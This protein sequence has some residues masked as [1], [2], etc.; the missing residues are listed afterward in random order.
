MN[1]VTLTW[2][3]KNNDLDA[4]QR[5]KSFF[6]DNHLICE[7]TKEGLYITCNDKKNAFSY[8]WWCMMELA[9]HVW[10]RNVVQSCVW[11]DGYEAEDV[12]LSTEELIAE[13]KMDLYE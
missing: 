4:H 1:E 7:E 2:E 10:F 3:N 9:K 13:G 12:I 5:I 6:E 11:T 8:I